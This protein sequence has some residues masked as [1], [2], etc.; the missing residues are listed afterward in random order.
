[1]NQLQFE[2][3]PYLKQHAHNPVDWFPWNQEALAKAKRENKPILISIGYS[4][5]H[6]CHVMERESFEDRD[7]ADMMNVHFVNIKIDREERPD[8]D[9]L[10][11]EAC[12]IITRTAA[13]PMHIFLTPNGKPFY[14]GTYFPPERSAKMMSWFQALQYASYN[15]R[16]N[17]TAVEAYADKI[18]A[19]MRGADISL[20]NALAKENIDTVFSDEKLETLYENFQKRFDEE[21]GG[22]GNATKFPNTIALEFLLNYYFYFKNKEALQ[23]VI[24]SVNKM[25]QGG[26]Y[27]QVGGGL[28]RYTIDKKWKIPHFEKMLY[29]NALFVQLL[30]EIYSFKKRTKYK[31]AIQETLDFIEREMMSPE[32]AF[33]AALDADTEGEEGKFYTWKKSE[34]E[35]A[36]GEDAELFCEFFGVEEN[37][38][39][40]GTNILFQPYDLFKFAEEKGIDKIKIRNKLLDLKSSL[41]PIRGKRIRP[42][43]DEKVLLNWNALM[44][45][46][47]AMAAAALG[48]E[49]YQIIAERN[50]DFLLNTF[51]QK[52]KKE[53]KRTFY[54]G[55]IRFNATLS[56]FALL[57]SA[58]LDVFQLNFKT[59]LLQTADELTQLVFEKFADEKSPLFFGTSSEEKDMILRIKDISDVDTPS[60]NSTMAGNLQRLGILLGK[61][62]YRKRATEMLS[63]M[64]DSM[65]NDPIHYAAWTKSFIAESKGRLEIAI[66]GNEAFEKA[67]FANQLFIPQKIIIASKKENNEIPLLENREKEGET[68]IYICQDYACLRPVQNVDKI[69]I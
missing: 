27:D 18:L 46:A 66:I 38:N 15:F 32:G 11:T 8:L 22:F 65:T 31:R 60:G 5:C 67:K 57:I 1:M 25:L 14:A 49:E 59:I 21:D 48:N 13:Y 29:D 20:D 61:E 56:D 45:S 9:E 44:C 69:E 63:T 41:L 52:E 36:L 12:K 7:V 62:N 42:H 6:W 17:K 16:E 53:L 33:F 26:I 51:Y 28:A 19:R 2:S 64:S 58:V 3:S 30:A 39:W 47:F 23:Q 54:D 34:I 43:R 68:W 10:Y 50:L 24:F 37:G 40:E 4:T 35:A 55:K